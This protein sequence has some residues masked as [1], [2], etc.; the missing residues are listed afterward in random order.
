[1]SKTPKKPSGKK[2]AAKKASRG[3]TVRVK[4][5]YGR[6]NSSNR[7]LQR[8]LNDPYVLAAKRDGYRSRSAYKLLELDEKF[9]FLKKGKQVVDLGAAPGGWLQVSVNKCGEGNVVALDILEMD[10]VPGTAILHMDFMDDDAPDA[11]KAHIT[12]ADIVLSDMA[13]NSSG[14]PDL[15]HMR[16]VIL[17]EAAFDFACEVLRPGGVFVAKVWQGG[18]ETALLDRIKKR[19]A[20]VK[21]A[22]PKSSRADSAETFLVAMGFR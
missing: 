10:A 7:W 8:Q 18:T 11:L 13:P 22:K 4:T 21:H 6:T 1:M 17:V 19:F 12:A 14:Q 20:I 3:M 2:P 16:I 5:A 15:D 9:H